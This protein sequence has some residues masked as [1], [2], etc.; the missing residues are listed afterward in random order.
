MAIE[1]EVYTTEEQRSDVR[2]LRAKGLN[3]KEIHK[4]MFP[5]YSG[6][7]CRL[8]RFTTGL[9]NCLKAVRKLQMMPD[10]VSLLRL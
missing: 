3:A 6:N 2:F 1:L 10:Q 7:V 4:E 8:K 9:I 5:L